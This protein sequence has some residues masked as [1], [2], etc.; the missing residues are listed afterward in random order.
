MGDEEIVNVLTSHTGALHLSEHAIAP[1]SIHHQHRSATA[2][3]REARVIASGSQC[4][5]RSQ[6][7]DGTLILSHC[8]FN[9]SVNSDL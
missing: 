3:Q 7:G 6:H 8:I 9:S 4:I 2:M 5:S 1:T